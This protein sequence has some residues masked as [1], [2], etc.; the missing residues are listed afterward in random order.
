MQKAA[1]K[2]F[3]Y[4]RSCPPQ[5]I[6]IGD[7]RRMIEKQNR[8]YDVILLDA[9]TSDGIPL[10]LVTREAVHLYLAHLNP[11]GALLFHIS[12]RYLRLASP[13]E[14][15]AE[16]EGLKAYG[17]IYDPG[18]Q[19]PLAFISKWV[20]IP[21]NPTQSR[22]LLDKHWRGLVPTAS[23]WTDDKSSLLTAMFGQPTK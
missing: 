5:N 18:K 21:L 4:L 19:K 16:A 23:V 17:K 9:F 22:I 14:A 20:V 10:H 11:G 15:V 3:S 8:H 7:G 6:F 13:I 12:N 1:E 2:Y